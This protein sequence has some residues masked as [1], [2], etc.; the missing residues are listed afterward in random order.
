[1]VVVDLHVLGTVPQVVDGVELSGLL[2]QVVDQVLALDPREA[3]D[4]EDVLLRVHRRDLSAGL[5]Q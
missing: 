2:D 3:G 4:V 5:D 1:M